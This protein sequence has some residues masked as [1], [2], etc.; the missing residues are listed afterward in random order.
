MNNLAPMRNCPGGA[1]LA[2]LAAGV[3]VS[4]IKFGES[5]SKFMVPIAL[6]EKFGS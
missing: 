1:K 3:I 4:A 6:L 5:L 2:K